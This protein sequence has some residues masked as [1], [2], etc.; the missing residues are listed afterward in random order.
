M[1]NNPL[2][3]DGDAGADSGEG[4]HSDKD[5]SVAGRELNKLTGE[6]NISSSSCSSPHPHAGNFQGSRGSITDLLGQ[7]Y[8]QSQARAGN[9]RRGSAIGISHCIVFALQRL[10]RMAFLISSFLKVNL[11]IS[12]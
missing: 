2:Q 1:K 11:G 6:R 9:P 5:G 10:N 3:D 7:E 12:R 4:D 8:L